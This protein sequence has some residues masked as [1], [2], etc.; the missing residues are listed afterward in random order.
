MLRAVRDKSKQFRPN[1][2]LYDVPTEYIFSLLSAGEWGTLVQSCTL[3][4]R[5]RP[6]T[7]Q[8]TPLRLLP[9]SLTTASTQVEMPIDRDAHLRITAM[10]DYASTRNPGVQL[11]FGSCF[12][13]QLPRRAYST[14][15]YNPEYFEQDGVITGDTFG[16][17][18]PDDATGG[19]METFIIGLGRSLGHDINVRRFEGD[20]DKSSFARKEGDD[21]WSIDRPGS[22]YIV[23]SKY[24][25]ADEFHSAHE[26]YYYKC[27]AYTQDQLLPS[28]RKKVLHKPQ[29]VRAKETKKRKVRS[30]IIISKPSFIMK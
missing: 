12:E 6:S 9:P 20:G 28:G 10:V 18:I 7:P 21:V 30:D 11:K 5:M 4:N 13:D 15:H 1:L 16:I 14:T 17:R 25:T 29:K 8:V 26:S 2:E 23:P 24:A 19:L 27:K 3:Y 22:L